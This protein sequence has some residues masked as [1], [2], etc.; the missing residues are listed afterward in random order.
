MVILIADWERSGAGAGMVDNQVDDNDDDD[1]GEPTEYEFIDG[2]DRK[3]FLRDH[4]PHILY[5]WHLMHKFGILQKVRQQL[6]GCSSVDGPHAPDD[7]TTLKKRKQSPR[8]IDQSTS[9]SGTITKNMEQIA[10]SI[11]GLVDVA[12]QSHETQQVNMLCR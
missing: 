11:N 12:R 5:L 9:N 6:V 8:S 10:D 1:N 3:S 4:P 7:D 2:D